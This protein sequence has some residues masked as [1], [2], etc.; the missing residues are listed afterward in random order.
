MVIYNH[1]TNKEFRMKQVV[2]GHALALKVITVKGTEVQMYQHSNGGIFGMDGSFLDQIVEG[3][4]IPDP[5]NEG[6]SVQLIDK[7]DE[8][9]PALV[10]GE[11]NQELIDKV[12]DDLKN[13]FAMGDYTT[14]DELL[15]FLPDHILEGHLGK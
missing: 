12:I 3:D 1:V 5:F 6:Y 13:A 11:P 8:K 9:S 15:S 7:M 10:S 2:S 4:Y 14:L